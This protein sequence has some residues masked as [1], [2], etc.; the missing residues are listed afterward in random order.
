MI[1]PAVPFLEF[2]PKGH[3]SRLAD[4]P[5]KAEVQTERMSDP[6]RWDMCVGVRWLKVLDREQAVWKKKEWRLGA[7]Y[8]NGTLNRIWQPGTVSKLLRELGVSDDRS[9]PLS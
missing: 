6:S 4:L 9:L 3:T 7:Q 1:S 5:L 2:V 8:Y